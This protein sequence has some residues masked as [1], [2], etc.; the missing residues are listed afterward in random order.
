MPNRPGEPK[1]CIVAIVDDD[2]R[3]LESLEDLLESERYV[4]F[5]F[6]SGEALLASPVWNTLN[7]L[8][9]DVCL[10]KID[11]LDLCR[12]LQSQRSGVAMILITGSECSFQEAKEFGVPIF[13]KP[14]DVERL[15]DAIAGELD[16]VC[17]SSTL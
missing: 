15:L 7:L 11:G 5:G 3:V 16:R 9:T 17:G 6:P 2:A 4:A 12:R 13:F 1:P 10:P 8:I 14:L